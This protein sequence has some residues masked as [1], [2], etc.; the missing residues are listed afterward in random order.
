[1]IL[2][3]E[4]IEYSPITRSLDIFTIGCNGNCKDCCNPEIKDFNLS[5][6]SIENAISKVCGL[7]NQFDKLIDRIFLV[8]GDPVDGEIAT[9]G[10]T[11]SLAC[12]IKT[13]TNKP[14][15]LFTRHN[16]EDI[17][18][19]LKECVDYIKTGAYIPELTTNDNI[20]YG[21]KLATSNQRI[22]KKVNGEWI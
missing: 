22:Y 10:G 8:G 14:I 20:Q 16:L 15:Y 17:P 12:H 3:I 7:N 9:S 13:F 19:S 21:I 4:H 5:G 1:M 18:E 2:Q 11:R 6:L